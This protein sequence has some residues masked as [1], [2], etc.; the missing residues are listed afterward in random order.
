MDNPTLLLGAV[1][2]ALLLGAIDFRTGHMPNWLNAGS[3]VL[4]VLLQWTTTRTLGLTHAGW[5]ILACGV[6]PAVLFYFSRGEGIGGG[7]VKALMVL[8]AWLGADV[9]LECELLAFILLGVGALLRATRRGQAGAL[10][11]RAA[12]VSVRLRLANDDAQRAPLLRTQERFGPYLASS[13]VLCCLNQYL[14]T[15]LSAQHLLA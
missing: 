2:T 5:G 14:S 11:K 9:G 1:C 10:L 6:A 12:H 13:T 3:F 15:Y 8:G 7:D 4:A